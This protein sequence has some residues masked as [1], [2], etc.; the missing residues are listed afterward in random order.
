MAAFSSIAIGAM[1]VAGA[2]SAYSSAEAAN[3]QA[4]AQSEAA[5]RKYRLESGVAENQMDEQQSIALQQMTK[6]NR[7]YMVAKSTAKAQQAD[8]GVAG[9]SADRGKSVMRTKASEAKGEVA[10]EVDTNVINIAQGML[11]SKIEAENTIADANAK[12]RNAL[13][14]TVIGGIQ[15]GVQGYG[16]G[17]SIASGGGGGTLASQTPTTSSLSSPSKYTDMYFNR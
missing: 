9:V 3:N 7:E 17:K 6:V 16:M 15:G 11:A 13:F 12:R 14:D 1:A 10:S 4:D 5:N 2:A 8:M